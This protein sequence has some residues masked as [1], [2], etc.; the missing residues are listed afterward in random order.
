ME[1]R[2]ILHRTFKDSE[3]LEG[4]RKPLST[5]SY[6]LITIFRNEELKREI[7]IKKREPHV[8]FNSIQFNSILHLPCFTGSERIKITH[9]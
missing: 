2:Y 8:T 9:R 6:Q 1:V 4:N 3:T 5:G 7:I